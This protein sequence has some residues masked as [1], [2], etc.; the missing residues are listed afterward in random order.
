V[1]QTPTDFSRFP[2]M[3]FAFQEYGQA[4]VAGVTDNARIRE[5]LGSVGL[6][7]EHDETAWCSG[8]VN[9][10]LMKANIW[11]TG[12]GNARSFLNNW[13]GQSLTTPSFGCI[14]VFSRPPSPQKGHVAFYT[15]RFGSDLLVLGGN[16][17][18]KVCLKAYP[19]SRLLGHLLPAG[20]APVYNL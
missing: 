6:G 11:R 13:N 5:F 3:E 16:Q 7:N 19:E 2:W 12:R 18:N 20:F 14:T 17:G 15:G 9:W 4:E 10:C 8:F 1:L